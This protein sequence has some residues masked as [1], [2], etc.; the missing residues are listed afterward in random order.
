MSAP[1]APSVPAPW[2]AIDRSL[3]R[4]IAT[5]RASKGMSW[6]EV[7][8]AVSA[9]GWEIS[10]GNLM[11]RHSRMAFRADELMVLLWVLGVK[12]IPVQV[13]RVIT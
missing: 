6:E 7:A 1:T 12:E 11:T 8:K 10:A 13:P 4:L 3:R 2:E 5:A 9:Q